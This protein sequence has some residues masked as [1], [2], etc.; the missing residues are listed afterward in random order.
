[1]IKL[2]ESNEDR[3]TPEKVFISEDLTISRHELFLQNK[4]TQEK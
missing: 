1:M 3:L 2:N 4:K